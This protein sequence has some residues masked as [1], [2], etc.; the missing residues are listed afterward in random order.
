MTRIRAPA[1]WLALAALSPGCDSNER[2]VQVA[3]EAANRQA[4]QNQR[5]AEL[6]REVTEGTRRLVEA[7]ADARAEFTNLHLGL[8]AERAEVGEQRDRLE[9]ERRSIAAW[10]L[11]DSLTAA[12]VGEAATLLVCLLPL[13]VCWQLLRRSADGPSDAALAELLMAEFTSDRP[14]LLPAVEPPRIGG[15]GCPSTDDEPPRPALPQA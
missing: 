9:E 14:V 6:Q 3:T 12:A 10:R 8:E 2:V 1:A 15:V 5:M 13:L 7:E 11:T 4:E